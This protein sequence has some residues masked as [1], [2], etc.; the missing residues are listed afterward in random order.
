MTRKRFIKL[1][2]SECVDKRYAV[3]A[4]NIARDLYGSYS[5]AYNKWWGIISGRF[6]ML[7]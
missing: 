4:A 3:L 6:D 5:N 2:M 1:A 7:L